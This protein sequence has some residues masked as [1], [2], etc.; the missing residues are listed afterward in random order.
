MA[1]CELTA[2]E[3]WRLALGWS[4]PQAIREV[5][6]AYRADGLRPPGLTPAMLCRYEHGR[7]EPGDEYRLMISRA[8]GA[9]PDQL[10]LET[11]CLWCHTC[12]SPPSLHYG[13]QREETFTGRK[14][15]MTTAS[16][17]PAIRESVQWAVQDTPGGSP[18]LVAL[19]EAAVEHYALNYSKHPPAVLF[20]EVRA[21]RNLLSNAIAAAEPAISR[22]LRR[23]VGWL[24]ALLG[25][26]CHHLDD[27]TGARAHLTLACTFGESTGESALTAWASGALSMVAAARQDWEHAR[28]HADYG[29]QHAPAGLRR[30]QLL[31]WALLPTLA[32]LH[33]AAE[34]DDV[35]AESDAI[36][37]SGMELPGRFGYDRAEHRLHVAEA[38]LT[39][40]RW[41]L[42]ADVA[43]QSIACAPAETPGWVAAT[44][45]LALAEARDT[46]EQAADRALSV[47]D[48]IPPPRLRATSRH[49]LA[50][51]GRLLDSSTSRA[52]ELTERLRTLPAPIHPDGT[53][54]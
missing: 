42:A 21:T 5:A 47:L 49:R 19:A 14:G 54:A 4:R 29:L 7:E 40:E 26:L 51:L 41:D 9:R 48:L 27:R 12:A 53:A 6:A 30:A 20:A 46:P 16:G 31:G 17:L 18:A 24:S 23:Q 45:V 25:N 43:R 38:Y 50:R 11:R 28:E 33:Q 44:L 37:A 8:Y 39:L 36:M 1:L 34:A 52:A 35:I 22:S 15:T 2:L 32:A 10:G 3:A 13:Q